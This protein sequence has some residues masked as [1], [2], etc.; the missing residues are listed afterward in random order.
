[1]NYIGLCQSV[2]FRIELGFAFVDDGKHLFKIDGVF[3][4]RI[5]RACDTEEFGNDELDSLISR[6]PTIFCVY[7]KADLAR[8]SF[9]NQEV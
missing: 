1:M 8:T 7:A 4:E 9:I 5:A 3:F 2:K 6:Y